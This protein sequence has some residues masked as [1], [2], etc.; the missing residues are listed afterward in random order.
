MICRLDGDARAAAWLWQ[1]T[2]SGAADVVARTAEEWVNPIAD[3]CI[4]RRRG[5]FIVW[6]SAVYD[7]DEAA[8][9]GWIASAGRATREAVRETHDLCFGELGLQM[10]LSFVRPE[11]RRWIDAVKRIGYSEIRVPDLF[12]E[13]VDGSLVQ[14]NRAAWRESRFRRAPQ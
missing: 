6:A 12:G 11:N 7:I 8:G 9:T 1:E 2:H 4:A 10:V 13:G 5:D 3:A 14:I